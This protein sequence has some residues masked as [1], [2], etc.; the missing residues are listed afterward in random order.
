MPT[1]S[2]RS[3][4]R[5]KTA[6]DG[7]VHIN[8]IT[9][10]EVVGD[11]ILVHTKGAT[12]PYPRPVLHGTAGAQLTEA[13]LDQLHIRGGTWTSWA[14][15]DKQRLAATR[16]LAW[17]QNE[18]GIADLADPEFT[19]ALAW[20]GV[21]SVGD[22]GG[23]QRNFRSFLAEALQGIRSDAADHRAVLHGRSLPV[24]EFDLQGYAP[25]VADA[26][27]RVAKSHVGRWFVQHR[28]AVREALGGDLPHDWMRLPAEDLCDADGTTCPKEFVVLPHDLAAAMVLL[29]LLDDKGPNLSVIH[30]H[31]CDSVEAAGDAAFV[32]SVKAR[33]RQVLRT[34]A[35][36]GGLYSYAGLLEFVTAATRVER[37]IR[38]DG[39]DFARLL[40]V[41]TGSDT[42]VS[43]EQVRAW[44]R[45]TS[46]DWPDPAVPRPD[47]LSFPRLR[48]AALLRGRKHQGTVVGHSR[49]TARLYLADAVPDVILIPGL[50]DTQNSVSDYCRSQMLPPR[51]G[52]ED[53]ANGL[54]AAPAVMDVGVAMCASNGQSPTDAEKP[55]G[56]GPVA[57]FLCPNGYRTPE[58]I[59]GLIAAVEFADGIRKHEPNEW[60]TSEA[61]VLH[62]LAS[63]ALDQFPQPVVAAASREDVNN[64]RALIACVY[65]EGRRRD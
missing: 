6:D 16:F 64:A 45:A 17:L 57:C 23:I 33:N 15:F 63:K 37:H 61:P 28:T 51:P 8:Y 52:D 47:G 1:R 5:R 59:P 2:D 58:V 7:G 65:V 55:C 39:S 43:G 12:R 48:K 3:V 35:P 31:T 36:N 26:I 13:L 49:S 46:S 34:P 54:S 41:A 10:A 20:Q 53:A 29:S 32:T 21:M 56:L 42:V 18:V 22:T 30:S 19:P 14:T 44:W 27:E 25:E 50:V 40:F 4:P 62:T 11:T 9:R 24:D 38:D 60:L